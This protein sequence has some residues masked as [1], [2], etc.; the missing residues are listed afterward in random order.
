MT[1]LLTM[2]SASLLDLRLVSRAISTGMGLIFGGA[3]RRMTGLSA[4]T[5]WMKFLAVE[6][7]TCGGGGGG[8]GLQGRGR[9]RSRG[10]DVVVFSC[11]SRNQV[12]KQG[13]LLFVGDLLLR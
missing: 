6:T 8:E 10:R 3:A 4:V 13:P 12:S 1:A 5:S 9:G 11:D 7:F 2:G